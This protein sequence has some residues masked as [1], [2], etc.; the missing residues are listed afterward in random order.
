MKKVDLKHYV[1][2]IEPSKNAT[3]EWFLSLL[4]SAAQ[5]EYEDEH[6]HAVMQVL[7]ATRIIARQRKIKEAK[8]EIERI[9]KE[10][11]NNA[12]NYCKVTALLESIKRA[13]SEIESFK[14]FF[15]EPY[16]ARMDLIDQKEGY[17]SYYIG[18]KGDVG[19]EIVDW[20]AP[21]ARRYYQKSRVRFSIN[22]YDYQTILR[23]AIK[24]KDGC[25][26][27]FKNEFL[28]V[29]DYLTA[30]EIDGRDEEILFD[31]YLREIIKTRKDE[32][33]IKDIIETI[34]ETQYEIITCPERQNFVL[35]GCAGSGKTMVMLHRLSYLMYNN[36]D[37]KSRDVLMLTPSNS[38]NAFIDEL[39]AV[40]ELERVRTTTLHD[41]FLQV[42][43][44]AHVPIKGKIDYLAKEPVEYLEYLYSPRFK[45]DLQ[46]KLFKVYDNLYGL[47]TGEECKEF[48]LDISNRLKHQLALYESI[49]NSSVRVRRVVLG[50][51][52]EKPEG[53]LYYTRPFRGLMNCL[54][55]VQDFLNGTLKSAQ[56]KNPAYF[57][58]QLCSFYKS[59]AY[60]SKYVEKITSDAAAELEN[61]LVTVEKEIVDLK[62]YKQF[63]GNTQVYVYED[64]IKQ[65]SLLCQE[66][67]LI[68][69][70]V[71]AIG[72]ESVSFQE[73]YSFLRG[74]KNF[75]QVGGGKS[76]GDIVRFFYKETIKKYKLSYGLEKGKMYPSDAYALCALCAALGAN[77]TPKHSFVFVDE[78]QDVS[79][80]EYELLKYINSN[81][82]FNIFGD[83]KQNV[84]PH[85]G[86]KDWSDVFLDYPVYK[87][88][89]NY[90]NTNQIV[91]FVS[92]TLDADMQPMGFDGPNVQ[93]IS[94]REIAS[95][96]K[97]TKGLKALI[98][99]EKDIDEY[100][101][102]S[103]NILSEKGKLSR[104]KI[105]LMTVYES[106]GLEFTSV[107][108]VDKRMTDAE[109]Y[110]AYTRALKLL[111][112]IK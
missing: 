112:V 31:P 98:C 59:A 48:L 4:D 80:G 38:F 57:Y 103:Y 19:L 94:P 35:Q 6:I 97:D 33:G 51:I 17:N 73:F 87:L 76:F 29:K 90:R 11:E 52:K 10:E 12:E 77:L 55:D 41:Y 88:S 21:L 107:A 64:R 39:S 30:E 8:A 13:Q 92:E 91:D 60:T 24:T 18:K 71:L 61:L 86:V 27:D 15:E 96:F 85:R 22:E 69:Q 34:Q 66:I 104:S 46:K 105:N 1:N 54:L 32:P 9:H 106:K 101:K 68:K 26:E 83:L 58:R 84:T 95:F 99:S 49:K 43:E 28:S 93:Q 82:A 56:A 110:I 89:R 78:A 65:K 37:I 81:A 100:A 23:R 16:F 79:A 5:R 70:K 20:R 102:K 74:E 67:D 7:R 108:V 36:E 42:L 47:F 53:G 44:N 62:R 109:K 25:V 72:D 3:K 45:K 75:S 50:E 40:L 111:A 2:C 14:P 63:V